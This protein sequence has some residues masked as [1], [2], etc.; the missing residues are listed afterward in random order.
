MFCLAIHSGCRNNVTVRMEGVPAG[1]K[2]GFA[3]LPGYVTCRVATLSR[4]GTWRYAGVALTLC[5]LVATKHYLV[6]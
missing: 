4:P 6:F 2:C 1:H 3:H 5:R